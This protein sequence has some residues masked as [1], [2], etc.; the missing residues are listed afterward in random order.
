M[1]RIDFTK[2][3]TYLHGLIVAAITAA[4]TA[5]VAAASSWWDGKSINWNHLGAI[6]AFTSL[7]TAFAYVSKNPI[8]SVNVTVEGPA[9]VSVPEGATAQVSTK[10]SSIDPT[11]PIS[12]VTPPESIIK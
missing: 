12:S 1:N 3:E 4:G 5:A 11:K 2:L 10:A 7:M 6:M 8:P 9:T